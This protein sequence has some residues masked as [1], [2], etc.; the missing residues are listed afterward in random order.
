MT[1][2]D[3]KDHYRRPPPLSRLGTGTASEQKVAGN[4]SNKGIQDP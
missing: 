4:V 2:C 3:N 1:L